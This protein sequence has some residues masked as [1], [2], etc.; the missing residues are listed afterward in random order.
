MLHVI[1]TIFFYAKIITVTDNTVTIVWACDATLPLFGW[2]YLLLFIVC[3]ALFILLLTLNVVLLF[4]KSL[5]RFT[6]VTRFKPLI[7]AFQ[8]GSLKFNI[9]NDQKCHDHAHCCG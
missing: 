7:D 4:T 5:M 8:G 9:L 2:K 1:A 6:I 3:I